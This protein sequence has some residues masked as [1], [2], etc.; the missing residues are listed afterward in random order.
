[1]ILAHLKEGSLQ[2]EVGDEVRPGMELGQIGNSGNTS[3]PH[4][5]IHA[6]RGEVLDLDELLFHGEGVP[7]VFEGRFL[8]RNDRVAIR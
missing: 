7:I 3:E 5:H 6:V 2:V 1:V 8:R 4:L